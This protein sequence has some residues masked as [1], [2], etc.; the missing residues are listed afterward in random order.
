M[1]VLKV[2][3]V[4]A[5]AAA[6]GWIGLVTAQNFPTRP[7]RVVLPYPAGTGPDAVMRQVGE[8]LTQRWGQP[9]TI[10]NRAGANG[11]TAAEAVKRAAPDG[12]TLIQGDNLLF[13]LQPFVFRRLPFDPVRDFEPVAPLY[14]THFFLVVPANSS[15]RNLPDLLMAA[16][17]RNGSL[18]YGSSGVASH[19][20]LG[21][22]MLEGAT[23]VTM[24]HVPVRETPQVF[25][26]VANGEIDWA[27]GTASTTGP[28]YRAQRIRYLAIAA[29]TRHPSFPDVP[30]MA[31][32]GGPPELELKAWIALFAPR[33]TPRPI[34]DRI[35]AEIAQVLSE[36]EI[37]ERMNAVGFTPWAGSP[38]EL[39][40][41]VTHDQQVL[42]DVARRERISFD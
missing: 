19:M 2:V 9:V 31:E 33:G 41:T 6:L 23:G 4:A 36:P 21:G 38:E 7:V 39:A 17:A 5:I 22:A 1:K 35:N 18:T 11:W 16:R 14:Q 15:W 12:Y 37:R 25:V 8:R 28:M 40:R 32:A 20:H 42:G 27:F 24:T 30:T 26:S 34:V 29:P 13:A 3:A 10:E